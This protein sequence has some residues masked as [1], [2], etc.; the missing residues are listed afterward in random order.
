M[1]Y[2]PKLLLAIAPPGEDRAPCL[3][4]NSCSWSRAQTTHESV[5]GKLAIIDFFFLS[6]LSRRVL[7]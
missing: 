5:C 6:G 2:F 3:R 1:V 4:R 7:K